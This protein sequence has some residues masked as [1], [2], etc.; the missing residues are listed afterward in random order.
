[1]KDL[2]KVALEAGA[3]RDEVMSAGFM[4]VLMHGGPALMYLTPIRQ[5]L[6]EFVV[7]WGGAAR[8]AV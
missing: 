8:P 6:D 2:I 5:A 1:M 3:S 4:A 7:P